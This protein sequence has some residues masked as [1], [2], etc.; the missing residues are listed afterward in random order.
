MGKVILVFGTAVIVV[1]IVLI[2]LDEE[3]TQVD[4]NSGEFFDDE[5]DGSETEADGGV[6][7]AGSDAGGAV[8]TESDG[9]DPGDGSETG[10]VN[11]ENIEDPGVEETNA[12]FH[13]GTAVAN[14][15]C[16]PEEY[17]VNARVTLFGNGTSRLEQLFTPRG[18]AFD[19]SDGQWE[20]L[21]AYFI[22]NDQVW[23]L[24]MGERYRLYNAYSSEPGA[25]PQAPNIGDL[26]E[27]MSDQE[28]AEAFGLSSDA[29]V[30][31]FS[32]VMFDY[33]PF[34]PSNPAD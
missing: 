31:M 10:G 23:G 18:N 17:D 25:P 14:D 12:G 26:A 15:P 6:G 5:S 29:C 9:T 13:T 7:D 34:P 33:S 11:S 27:G 8:D 21:V 16:G 3:S 20:E 32:D 30:V 28:F 19:T 22:S 24:F 2:S 4:P 1:S